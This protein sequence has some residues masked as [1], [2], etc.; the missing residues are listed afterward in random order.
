MQ[1]S[2]ARKK[3][4]ILIPK[5]ICHRFGWHRWF[6]TAKSRAFISGTCSRCGMKGT[7]FWRRQKNDFTK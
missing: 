2:E 7:E 3:N 6:W 4:I 1:E 5:T